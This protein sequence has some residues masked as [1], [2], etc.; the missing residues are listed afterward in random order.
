MK[1]E[2]IFKNPK[3]IPLLIKYVK[4]NKVVFPTH[5]VKYL[6]NEEIIKILKDCINNQTIY[7]SNYELVKKITLLEDKELKT[8]YP[9]IKESMEKINYDYMKDVNDLFYS[10]N[11]RK[12]GKKYTFEEHLK[13]LIIAQLSNHR[14]GDNNIRENMDA[15]D[16]IFHNYNKNYLKIV[17]SSILVK[18]LRSIH[19]TN[20]MINNQMKA[21]SKNIMVLEKIEK[22]Y[23]SLDNFVNTE[24]P[25][26]IA[27]MLN[28]GKYKMAQVGR[29]FAY[30]YLK[31]VGINTCKKSVQLKRLFGSHR[32]GIVE[33]ENATEQQVLNIIKKI[34][35]LNNC[36]EIV[37]ESILIQFCLLRSANI[38]GEYPNCEKCKIRSYCNYNNNDINSVCKENL[39]TE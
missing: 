23:G 24:S 20:P 2:Q 37:V 27:N 9:L 35:N 18:K 14:W 8:I 13:A 10:V 38:C 34:A 11:L 19:C 22:D 15:I 29:A 5:E 28:D 16:E 3:L 17:D 33:N 12:N 7:N 30:D 4:I 39:H 21:L 26:D 32:L 31:R 6:S 1:N 25:N 36:D